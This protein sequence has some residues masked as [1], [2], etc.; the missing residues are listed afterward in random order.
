MQG[1]HAYAL[2]VTTLQVVTRYEVGGALGA[3]VD[4]DRDRLLVSSLWVSRCST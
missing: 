4:A 1:R 2:D 3:T